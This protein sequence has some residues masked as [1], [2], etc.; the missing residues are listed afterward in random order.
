MHCEFIWYLHKLGSSNYGN[1]SILTGVDVLVL[2]SLDCLFDAFNDWPF[3]DLGVLPPMFF[4]QLQ[5]F[6]TCHTVLQPLQLSSIE[7][8]VVEVIMYKS[9]PYY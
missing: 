4:D 9:V 8:S 7:A 5:V 3:F 1:P 2:V 6:K